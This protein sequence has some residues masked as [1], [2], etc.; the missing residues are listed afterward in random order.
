MNRSV[1]HW[2]ISLLAAIAVVVVGCGGSDG[3]TVAGQAAEQGSTSVGADADVAAGGNDGSAADP[4]VAKDTVAYRWNTL[5][6]DAIRHDLARPVVHARNLFHVSAAIY[7]AWAFYDPVAQ[8]YLLGRQRSGFECSSGMEAGSGDRALD[9]RRAISHAAYRLISFRFRFSP[10]AAA[11]RSRAEALMREL[12]MDPTDDSTDTGSGSAAALGNRI[13]QCY[14]DYG[15]ADGSNEGNGYANLA[16]AP[17]NPPIEPNLP[18][19]P[20]IVDMD[21]WQSIALPLFIDQAGNPINGVPTF[22]GAEWGAVAPFALQDSQRRVLERD[23]ASYTVWFDPGAPPR[24]ADGQFDDYQWTF[25][26]VA[27]WASHLDPGDGVMIDIS[28]A[29]IGNIGGDYLEAPI[30][31]RAFYD[32]G[33]GGDPGRG[34][35]LNPATGLAYASQ[36]VPRGDYARVLAE[37]WADGPDSETPPGHWFVILNDIVDHPS[38]GRTIPGVGTSADALEWLVKAHFALGGAMHDAA[39]AA[40]SI[41]GWYDFVRPLSAIRAMADAGQSS[42]PGAGDYS[43]R[44]IALQPGFVERVAVGDPLAGESGEHV[45][46]IKLY[47]W[48]GPA[49]VSDPARDTAGVGWILAEN[50]W[51]YQRPSFVTPPFA[52]Y[53]SG[54]STYSSAAAT[55]LERLTGDPFFPGGMAE[56]RVEA[57]AF[58]VFERGPS[59]SMS[60]QWATYRDAADQCSLSRIWGGIHPP[61]DDLPGRRIGR[62]IGEQAFDMAADLFNGRL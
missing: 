36:W 35:A 13:A 17:V 47:T 55:M 27:R 59:Q 6:L 14:I 48:R 11:T 1:R 2:S 42:E 29:A 33:A 18:G 60:L 22:L 24:I 51:P 21:R 53:V 26:L 61:A 37:F 5:L 40:W 49:H 45:G 52:G 46:K 44:G 25:S 54:H 57:N 16:Y 19:N 7:D 62:R 9:V 43:P 32:A 23:G 3:P 12:G 20:E 10:G 58:L 30:D 39:I 28:P 50:W 15:L 4:R 56:Y 31:P 8:P 34:H 41:K 38:L